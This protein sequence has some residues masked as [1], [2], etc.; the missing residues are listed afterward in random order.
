M[1]RKKTNVAPV[2]NVP[3][4]LL[5]KLGYVQMRLA[6]SR[7]SVYALVNQGKLELTKVLGASRITDASLQRLIKEIL[8]E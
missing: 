5:H 1:S 2:P 7:S 4:P 3:Q 8:P 6:I